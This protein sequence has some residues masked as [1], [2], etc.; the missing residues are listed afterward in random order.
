[1]LQRALFVILSFA[2]AA[3]AAAQ[4]TATAAGLAITLDDAERRALERNPRVAG[5]RLGTEAA[6]YAV[7]ESRTA[8]TPSLT[9]AMTQRSQTNPATSQLAGGQG[10]V[11]NETATYTSGISQLL[12]WGGGRYSVEFNSNR[13]ATSNVF[14]TLN[15]SFSSGLSA[16]F[17]Q[18]LLQGFR[19]DAPRAQMQIAD[20][21]R[22]IADVEVR[23]E[24]AVIL[25]G[26]RVAYWELVYAADALETARR[27]EALARRNLDDNTLRVQLGTLAPIDVVQ[28]EAEIASRHQ[29]TVQAEGAW[30]NAQVNLKQLIVRDTADPFWTATLLPVER[31]SQDIQTLDLHAAIANAIGSRTDLEIARK[32]QHSSDISLK[33]ADDQRKPAVD[34]VASYAASGVGGTRILRGTDALGSTIVGTVPGSYLDALSSLA[35]LDYPTWSVGVNLTLPLGRKAADAAYA[36]GI[37]QKR[38]ADLRLE[39]L[40]LQVAADVTRAGEAIRTAEEEVQ[41][42]LAARQLAAR[43]LDAEMA[44]RDAGLSTTF[45]V[46]QAQRDLATAETAEL[47]ARLDHRTAVAEFDRVQAAP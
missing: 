2:T 4:T 43:R 28:S 27:S 26:V 3:S 36:R 39:A 15:P 34:L 46:L 21:Q 41:A 38:Q 18:P 12:P 44:R 1:M 31:P 19:F 33:L 14:A 22:S 25:H 24:A 23:Q 7:A 16:T 35:G 11:T 32:Q 9:L 5:A 29:A 37:V 10:Q 8:F 45:L 20:I 47:R 40:E 13:S 17:T 6:D 30:R 42:A